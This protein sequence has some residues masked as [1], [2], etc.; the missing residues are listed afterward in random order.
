MTSLSPF[1]FHGQRPVGA[2]VCV[3]VC[4]GVHV[5]V[6]V[7]P[8]MHLLC[9]W[10]AQ[11]YTH[12][13]LDPAVKLQQ[14]RKDPPHWPLTKG[15]QETHTHTHTHTQ[16]HKSTMA[17]QKSCRKLHRGI[18]ARPGRIIF[19]LTSCSSVSPLSSLAAPD[20]PSTTPTPACTL[21]SSS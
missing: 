18:P 14:G 10:E 17:G 1:S 13:M 12:L 11:M 21:S 15:L 19:P 4:A 3:C 2:G 20:H 7:C 5:C 16:T 8:H 6:C 9:C